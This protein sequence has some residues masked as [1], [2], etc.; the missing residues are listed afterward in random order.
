MRQKERNEIER[1]KDRYRYSRTK[2]KER[3]KDT[4]KT[5][6]SLFILTL[7]RHNKKDVL[8]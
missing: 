6:L 5:S 8:T 3:K 4:V 7:V 1:K 2:K